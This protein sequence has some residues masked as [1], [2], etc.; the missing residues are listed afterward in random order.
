M[1]AIVAGATVARPFSRVLARLG[2]RDLVPRVPGRWRLLVAR[3]FWGAAWLVALTPRSSGRV[4]V[5]PFRR[6]AVK[7]W[8][9]LPITVAAA[10]CRVT[11]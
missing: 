3:W 8:A 6:R 5:T 7:P 10:W 1:L 4:R 11:F 9:R 2:V